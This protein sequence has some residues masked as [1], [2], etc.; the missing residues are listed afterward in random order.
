[1]GPKGVQGVHWIWEIFRIN[2]KQFC[3]YFSN[4]SWNFVQNGVFLDF[5]SSV[6]LWDN[7]PFWKAGTFHQIVCRALFV[8]RP[9]ECWTKCPKSGFKCRHS[10]GRSSKRVLYT[11]WY[12]CHHLSKMAYCRFGGEKVW[13]ILWLSTPWCVCFE[14]EIILTECNGFYRSANGAI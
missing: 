2:R 3:T 9:R 12:T 1:M 6:T 10:L 5:W 13:I 7:M 8:G 14:F 11:I 4:F